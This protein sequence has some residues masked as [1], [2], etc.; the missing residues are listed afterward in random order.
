MEV[1]LLREVNVADHFGATGRLKERP[2]QAGTVGFQDDEGLTGTD[3]RSKP[4]S[5]GDPP[6]CAREMTAV[7]YFFVSTQ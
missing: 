3:K 7:R 4:E 6:A 1:P 5:R 2:R